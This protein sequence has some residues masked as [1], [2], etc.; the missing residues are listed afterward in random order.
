MIDL[1]EYLL[2][3]IN[4]LKIHGRTTGHLSPLSLFWTGSGIELN[5]K[6]SE[7][8][9][10]LE[11]AYDVYEPWIAITVN[12]V[13]VSR[14]MVTA[15]E[16][17]IC[18]FRGM[19]GEV[20]KNIRIFKETQALNE[21]PNSRLQIHGLKCDGEFMPVEDR[22]YKIEFIGDSITS[23][24]GAVGS[25]EEDDWI[26]M[27][28]SSV[29]NYTY[30]VAKE[31]NADYRVISQS[32]WGV[33]T[34]YDNNPNKNIP[35]HYEKICSTIEG[36]TNKALGGYKDNNFNAWQPDV[37]VINLGTN[38]E[39]AFYNPMWKDE[40]TGRIHK[41][42]LNEDGTFDTEDLKNFEDAVSNFLIKLRKY[43]PKAHLIWA[44]GMLGDGMMPAIKRGVAAYKKQ[45]KDENVSVVLLPNTTDE[46]VGARL[47]PGILA[48]K[49][50]ANVLI[51]HIKNIL[52]IRI[53]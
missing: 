44:Y 11:A 29:E 51:E 27:W 9:V 28:F 42:R 12:G 30:M 33:Y 24:E 48:H 31:L 36:E 45:S 46:T 17:W 37:I 49:E 38:D 20:T 25:K 22:S 43:N 2:S 34:S 35:S 41:Q 47:H 6:A 52:R 13:L 26:M 3:D 10:K 8:W 14:Q 50:A 5:V 4:N 16:H 1:K 23:G 39:G 7:L 21:D 19:N 15:G 18:V 40:L 32:G 53:N